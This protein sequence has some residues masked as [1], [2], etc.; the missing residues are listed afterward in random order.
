MSQK[1]ISGYVI[2]LKEILGKGSYGSVIVTRFRSIEANR[3][4]P[5]CPVL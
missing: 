1:K 5:R 3:M 2:F 4:G